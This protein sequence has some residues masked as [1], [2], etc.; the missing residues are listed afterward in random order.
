MVFIINYNIDSMKD[1]IKKVL[2]EYVELQELMGTQHYD[3]RLKERFKEDI[4]FPIVLSTPDQGKLKHEIVGSYK[5]NEQQRMGILD[6][7]GLAESVEMPDNG[8]YGIKIYEFNLDYMDL[9]ID[10][11]PVDE[12]LRII[13]SITEGRSN[14]YL[15]DPE[16]RSTGDVLFMIVQNQNIK[17]I[18]YARSFNLNEKYNHFSGIYSM[19]DIWRIQLD[20]K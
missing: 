9:D 1:L 18:L 4:I 10:N 20:Q 17:T 7:I 2:K 13:K 14:L 16:T 11:L 3:K 12:R 8:E 15:Q 6:N 19:D 5:L